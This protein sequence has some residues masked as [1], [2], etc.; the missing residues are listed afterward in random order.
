[1]NMIKALM[2]SAV[3]MVA[4]NALAQRFTIERS[5][6]DGGGGTSSGGQ[7]TVSGTLGQPD[8]GPA[9]NAGRFSL[10]GGFWSLFALQTTG[11]PLL[12]L[13]RTPTNTIVVSWPSAATGFRLQQNN[14]LNIPAW[15]T[16]SE[17]VADNGVNK[18]IV[19]SPPAGNR[20]YRLINP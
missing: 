18:F 11:G 5:A 6:I 10:V 15:I 9:M 16:P 20:W 17:S 4:T 7:F 19:V 8:A 13:S 3:I 2:T 12:T 14:D 1:M